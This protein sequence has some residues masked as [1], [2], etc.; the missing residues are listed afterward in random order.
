MVVVICERW[1]ESN[2]VT[3]LR[4]TES[5][6]V[7]WL[8]VAENLFQIMYFHML[9]CSWN[10]IISKITVRLWSLK[11]EACTIHNKMFKCSRLWSQ[12]GSSSA[13]LGGKRINEQTPW[14]KRSHFSNWASYTCFWIIRSLWLF[15]SQCSGMMHT[16]GTKP[17]T[18]FAPEGGLSIQVQLSTLTP[19][20]LAPLGRARKAA[21]LSA[22]V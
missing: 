14:N 22:L 18:S 17:P 1:T 13:D 4:W 8:G 7:T 5:N 19:L 2:N 12:P 3:W 11:T 10:G 15:Q 20:L 6:N 16:H 21:V 9:Y